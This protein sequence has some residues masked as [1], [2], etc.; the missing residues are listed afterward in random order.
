M[1][2]KTKKWEEMSPKQQ[3]IALAKDVI[4]QIE[5]KKLYISQGQYFNIF[6]EKCEDI[7]TIKGNAQVNKKLKEG[8]IAC[9][10][11]A[12]GALFTVHMLKTNHFTFDDYKKLED[13]IGSDR[14]RFICGRLDDIFP[15][16][17]MNLMETAFEGE[18]IYSGGDIEEDERAMDFREDAGYE[19]DNEALIAIMENLIKNG[20][21]FIP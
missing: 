16:S 21:V 14:N 5:A 10:C 19:D 17:Q 9:E 15:Q 6:G 7:D 12:K 4:A 3:R 11:C 2:Q 20:G 8:E 1:K 18:I 13:K